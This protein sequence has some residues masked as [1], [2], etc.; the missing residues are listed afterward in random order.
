[1]SQADDV[2][3]FIRG[4]QAQ[5]ATAIAVFVGSPG[6]MGRMVIAPTG[7]DMGALL[8]IMAQTA[9]E[10]VAIAEDAGQLATIAANTDG[11]IPGLSD[12]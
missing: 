6:D 7:E 2:H 8:L 4:V 1:M 11:V 3:Q 5:G 12:G 10:L 9:N